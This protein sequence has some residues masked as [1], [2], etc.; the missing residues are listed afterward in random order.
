M[1][2]SKQQWSL[3][4]LWIMMMAHQTKIHPDPSRKR[5]FFMDNIYTR[6]VLARAL[7]TITQNEAKICGT[8]K[9]TNVD[10]TKPVTPYKGNSI[11]E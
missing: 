4:A 8:V 7:K 10:A 5:V 11:D 6:H 3:T 2:I 9:F 1:M